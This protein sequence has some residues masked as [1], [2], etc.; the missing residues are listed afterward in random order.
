MDTDYREFIKN[1]FKGRNKLSINCSLKKF[2]R[3]YPKAKSYLYGILKENPNWLHIRNIVWNICF[4]EQLNHC[5]YC[6]KELKYSRPKCRYK[7]CSYK[8]GG[9]AKEIKEKIKQT[10]LNKYGCEFPMQN[11]KVRERMSKT[12]LNR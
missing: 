4:G 9:L 3:E 2:Y 5:E 1:Y 7:Y 11:K 6:G 10:N 8:C 12:I